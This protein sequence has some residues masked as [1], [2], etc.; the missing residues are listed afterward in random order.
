MTD[1]RKGARFERCRAGIMRL[2]ITLVQR[3]LAQ[4]MMNVLEDR[5]LNDPDVAVFGHGD[6][7]WDGHYMRLKFT[8]GVKV[9]ARKYPSFGIW[10]RYVN[11]KMVFEHNGSVSGHY[12][13]FNTEI[14]EEIMG[15]YVDENFVKFKNK[16]DH[17][18]E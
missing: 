13:P 1:N 15:V 7:K 11:D 8:G 10:F 12:L 6:N 4:Q 17:P 2:D 3:I 18:S 16:W 9:S 14:T 5:F